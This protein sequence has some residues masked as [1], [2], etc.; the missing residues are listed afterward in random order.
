MNKL[1]F[2][3]IL[4][5]V[6]P[7]I[8]AYSQKKSSGSDPDYFVRITEP[9]NEDVK[10]G[11]EY[12]VK[13]TA[14]IPEGFYLYALCHRAD[15][16]LWWCQGQSKLNPATGEWTATVFIGEAK[17]I[18]WD[19]E[20]KVILIDRTT[21]AQLNTEMMSNRGVIIPDSKYSALRKVQK[22]TH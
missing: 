7:G 22:I 8:T 14:R 3:I 19:F 10:V 17:D 5:L 11:R 13:G 9:V 6:L 12:L 15:L 21:L 2:V 20:I 4:V 1:L 16:P 18:G